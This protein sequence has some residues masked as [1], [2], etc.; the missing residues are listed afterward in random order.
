MG[1]ASFLSADLEA[2][3]TVSYTLSDL[4][5]VSEPESYYTTV[6]VSRELEEP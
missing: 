5:S 1:Y 4:L 2:G 6:K 3:G